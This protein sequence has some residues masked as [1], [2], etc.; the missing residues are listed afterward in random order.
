MIITFIVGAVAGFIAGVL[1][2]PANK[3]KVEQ[4]VNAVKTAGK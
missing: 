1:V 3:G 4:A 2:G